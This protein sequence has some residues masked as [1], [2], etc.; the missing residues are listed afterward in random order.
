MLQQTQ[1]ERC[2][3]P[4]LSPRPQIMLMGG[5]HHHFLRRQIEQ[6][7]SHPVRPRIGLVSPSNFRAEHHI[8]L[9]TTIRTPDSRHGEHNRHAPTGP[10]DHPGT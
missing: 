6:F 4:Q 9:T 8:P 5:D 7:E 2:T 10:D 3:E 1:Y